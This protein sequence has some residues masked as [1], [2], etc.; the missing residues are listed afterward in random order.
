[1]VLLSFKSAPESVENGLG[2]ALQ[3]S[4][5]NARTFV[6]VGSLHGDL[7]LFR[8]ILSVVVRSM[9]LLSGEM[10]FKEGELDNPGPSRVSMERGREQAT[11]ANLT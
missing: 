3:G 1:M 8:K 5:D 9:L 4:A 6:N 11:V 2:K 10:G 7:I